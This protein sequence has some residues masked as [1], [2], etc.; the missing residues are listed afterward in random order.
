MRMNNL[1]HRIKNNFSWL[2]RRIGCAVLGGLCC[3]FLSSCIMIMNSLE[4]DFSEL[5]NDE[6]SNILKMTALNNAAIAEDAINISEFNAKSNNFFFGKSSSFVKNYFFENYG[7]CIENE[8][9]LIC[10]S[11][12]EW[13]LIEKSHMFF[14][15]FDKENNCWKPKAQFDF[16]FKIAA[17]KIE[18]TYVKYKNL[19]YENSKSCK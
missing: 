18:S 16:N 7:T 5:K 3:L 10:Q 13:R 12:R 11:T 9:S 15:I 1:S 8:K 2:L 4:D 19:T 6:I 14:G 17:G